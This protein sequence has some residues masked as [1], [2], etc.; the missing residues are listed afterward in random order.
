MLCG[1]SKS[2]VYYMVVY[3]IIDLSSSLCV[4][5]LH[6][7]KDN[8]S[9]MILYIYVWVSGVCSS[10]LTLAPALLLPRIQSKMVCRFRWIAKL[11]GK[12]AHR[13]VV[14]WWFSVANVLLFY[15]SAYAV[16]RKEGRKEKRKQRYE[17]I[18]FMLGRICFFWWYGLS[19]VSAAQ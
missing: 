15:A 8:N 11:L 3:S 2:N 9:F 16:G 1:N 19:V 10:V 4:Y 13:S 17:L 5:A 14:V 6:V 18:K 7:H 12:V